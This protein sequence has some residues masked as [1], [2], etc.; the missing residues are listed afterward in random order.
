M[1]FAA[2]CLSPVVIGMAVSLVGAPSGDGLAPVADVVLDHAASATL[3]EGTAAVRL[4]RDL[5]APAVVGLDGRGGSIDLGDLQLAAPATFAAWL[6]IGDTEDDRR[7]LSQL[8]GPPTQSGALRLQA[9]ALQVA[10]GQWQTLIAAPLPR[11][12]WLH[13]AVV[14]G[15]DGTATGYRDGER[16][17]TVRSGLDFAGVRTGIGARFIGEWGRPFVGCMRD[18]RIVRRALSAGE[19]ASICRVTAPNERPFPGAA[20]AGGPDGERRRVDLM[21]A[22]RATAVR[23]PTEGGP[24]AGPARAL[25]LPA[26]EAGFAAKGLDTDEWRE[27]TIPCNFE[28][29]GADMTHFRGTCWFRREFEV[30]RA[31]EG[32][33]VVVRFH[34]VSNQCGVWV[35]GRFAGANVDPFLPFEL[36]VAGLVRYGKPN[37]LAVRVNNEDPGSGVPTFYGWR[38]EGGILR[39]VE[40]EASSHLRLENIAITAGSDGALAV[41]ASVTNGYTEA[42]AARVDTAVR[43]ANGREVARLS[44]GRLT[45]SAS[46]C[47]AAS[48]TAIADGVRPW[49]PEEPVLYTAETSLVVDGHVV[50]RCAR[51]FG[52]RTI[53]TRGAELLLNGRPLC[54]LGFN[55]HEDS[56]RTGMA[57]DLET[58][59]SDLLDMKRLGANFVRL[60]HYPHCA[61]ELDLCDEIG[62]LCMG[63]IPFY[64][65]GLYG[66]FDHQLVLETGLRQLERMIRRDRCHPSVVLWSVGNECAEDQAAVREINDALVGRAQELDP[67]RLATH[68]SLQ[69]YWPDA[70][71]SLY[72]RDDVISVNAYGYQNY[73]DQAAE[74]FR[75]SLG[76]L[77]ARYPDRPI[78]VTEFGQYARDKS[79]PAQSV[80][81]EEDFRALQA[82]FVCGALIWCYANHGWPPGGFLGDGYDVST[83][84]VY[85]RNR[86][87]GRAVPLVARLFR[88]KRESLVR[89]AALP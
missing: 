41:S 86:T 33:R 8:D 48:A 21:G 7:V 51:R 18:V 88:E 71:L 76:G 11:E 36:D 60:C 83:Y 10:A 44:T 61:E 87:P 68:V 75:Q 24:P 79:T 14:Y 57:L 59:R 9:G 22:W 52:F 66:P 26:S 63:E 27:V 77:H 30:P 19:I 20:A 55:R 5:P 15:A 37:S 4:S 25:W 64:M 84:G 40:V 74:W 47:T 16:Q 72:A 1:T 65:G 54:L 17:A 43:D 46:S 82:P 32:R 85:Y 58:M 38:A 2:D 69:S 28:A 35:N 78:L 89:G 80:S 62:L 6:W 31:W 70:R 39:G 81:I 67:S 45:S 49:S 23:E 29:L 12:A 13:I 3:D 34:G 53:E 50:D 73:G 56:P 42:V